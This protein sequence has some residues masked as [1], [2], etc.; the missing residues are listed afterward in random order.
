M[1]S[2]VVGGSAAIDSITF[3]FEGPRVEPGAPLAL[4]A[5]N[6]IAMA[7]TEHGCQPRVLNAFSKEEWPA[8]GDRVGKHL[9]SETES[10]QA[11]P[12]LQVEIG[13]QVGKSLRVLAFSSK[14]HSPRKVGQK[15]ASV[16]MTF[17][18]GY[19]LGAVHDISCFVLIACSSGDLSGSYHMNPQPIRSARIRTARPL[20]PA[21]PDR[22]VRPTATW[23]DPAWS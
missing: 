4:L 23:A 7:V 8:G 1:L 9:A 19:H 21:R 3:A 2:L 14:C 20:C 22:S 11:R 6:H 17:D 10:L 12:H 15:I 16:E 5:S 13:T 18:T